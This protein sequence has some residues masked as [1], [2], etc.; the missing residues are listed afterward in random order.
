[1]SSLLYRIV[2]DGTHE[3]S[4]IKGIDGTIFTEEKI[5]A[6]RNALLNAIQ[7]D[8]TE[9][10]NISF[11]PDE[12]IVFTETDEGKFISNAVKINSSNGEEYKL[13]IV[14][15][16]I[17]VNDGDTFLSGTTV[18]FLSDTD[19]AEIDLT[20]NDVK[21]SFYKTDSAHHNVLS[22]KIT[23]IDHK[24]PVSKKETQDNE[25]TIK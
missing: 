4:E 21:I 2:T 3:P 9:R 6:Y 22:T 25:I 13:K 18:Q 11:S 17:T 15:Q 14:S 10:G 20:T 7:N 23:D 16:G 12:D 5:S 8:D 1:L 19:S 24:I